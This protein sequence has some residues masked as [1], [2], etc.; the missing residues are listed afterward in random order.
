MMNRTLLPCVLVLAGLVAGCGGR[1]AEPEPE[2]P[3]ETPPEEAPLDLSVFEP[4]PERV[5]DVDMARVALGRA[6]YHD[7]RLSGDGTIAC[8]T[9]HSLDHGGAEPR[10]VSTG[11][12]G[13]QGPINSPTVL[14][15]RYNFRQFWN[16][17]A[18]DLQ[19]QAAGPVANPIEMGA[20]W[21]Q[22]VATLSED[23]A[24]VARFRDAYGA[25]TPLDQEHVTDAIAE[26]ER[27]LVTPSPFDRY[28]R[29]DEAA[30]SAQQ[31]RGLRH[32]V[33]VGCTSCHRGRNLGGA[34]Y[35]RMGLIHDY[36]NEVRGGAITEADL[37]RFTVTGNETD[38]HMF[39]VPTLR[40]VALTAPYFHDGSQ[41][42]LGEVVRIMAHCQRGQELEDAVIDDIVAFLHSL[43]GE[44]PPE[45]RPQA[46]AAP[47]E[48]G[49]GASAEGKP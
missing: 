17:R 44:L 31:V 16:G 1:A 39:K 35:Q 7:T 34:M 49:E 24:F 10:P 4:L 12:A 23:P 19:E 29:G 6:L 3:A 18:A 37:G 22:V 48:A 27:Y 46:S 26:Y 8:V 20:D 9:C 13:Q 30:L 15:A 21:D 2:P 47:A 36:F 41:T 38:R 32:F 42:D 33:E 5:E 43:T 45:A 14:N 25:E 40:N 28:L 11:I